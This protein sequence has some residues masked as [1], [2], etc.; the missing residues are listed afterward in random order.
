[1]QKCFCGQRHPSPEAAAAA[2]APRLIRA[3]DRVLD[4]TPT[5]PLIQ[6]APVEPVEIETVKVLYR[7][8]EYDAVALEGGGYQI[9]LKS[10]AQRTL[11]P[12]QVTIL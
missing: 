9:T 3:K 11:R 2:H 6:A 10:G 4:K 7:K 5:P 8:N 12:E 1:M